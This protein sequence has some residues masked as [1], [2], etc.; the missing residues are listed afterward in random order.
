MDYN[1]FI[2]IIRKYSFCTKVRSTDFC[3]L[4]KLGYAS[5][6][7]GYKWPTLEELYF[8]LFNEKIEQEHLADKDVEIL[9]KCF[10]KGK[11]Q[12]IF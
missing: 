11:E 5:K 12:N 2:N 10:I 9:L 1:P 6:Y 8:K 4:P 3:K 7:P